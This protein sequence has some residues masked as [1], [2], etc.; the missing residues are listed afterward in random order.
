MT[1]NSGI[2]A[3]R[4]KSRAKRLGRADHFSAQEWEY[5]CSSFNNRCA[6]CRS[7]SA[8]TPDHI[9]P[10]GRGGSNSIE[11]IQP[12][13]RLCNSHKS[14]ATADY[15]DGEHS[16]PVILIGNTPRSSY[17][18][19][20]EDREL[21]QFIKQRCGHYSDVDAI[22]QALRNEVKRLNEQTEAH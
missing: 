15:R 11:N 19:T 2:V 10:L 17:R 20:D 12:L 16:V 1:S 9:V 21:I 3:S 4:Q 6:C 18:F 22:R 5:L 7:D 8:L 14:T 13:C